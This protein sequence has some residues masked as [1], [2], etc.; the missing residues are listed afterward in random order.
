VISEAVQIQPRASAD[1]GS[2]ATARYAQHA[3]LV[4]QRTVLQ[5][6]CAYKEAH[7][8]LYHAHVILDIMATAINV[9][10]VKSARL[11]LSWRI[12]VLLEV[13]LT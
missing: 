2:L 4:L 6:E 13:Q 8:M 11:M 12:L 1:K 5:Q 9:H 3:R 10:C 7:A